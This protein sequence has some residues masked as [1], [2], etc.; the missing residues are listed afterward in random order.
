MGNAT[1]DGRCDSA[2]Q[3]R[4]HRTARERSHRRASGPGQSAGPGGRALVRRRSAAV[5][6]RPRSCAGQPGADTKGSR[7]PAQ[8]SFHR[9]R[10]R[11]EGQRA[12]GRVGGRHRPP[13]S[14]SG[15]FRR[16][17]RA[18]A[19]AAGGVRGHAVPCQLGSQV[20]PGLPRA[21]RAAAPRKV[22]HGG[23]GRRRAHEANLGG[24]GGRAGADV[25]RG[26]R[27]RAR[28]STRQ[29]AGLRGRA[30]GD[31]RPARC[32]RSDAPS[33]QERP[34]QGGGLHRSAGE[35]ERAHRGGRGRGAFRRARS[36][37]RPCAGAV[38][39]ARRQS[40]HLGRGLRADR[41]GC[42]HARRQRHLVR[43]GELPGNAAAAH[44]RRRAG[45]GVSAITARTPVPR[46]RRR[47]GVGRLARERHQCKRMAARRAVAR[48]DRTG[49]ALSRTHQGRG[50]RRIVPHRRLGRRDGARLTQTN[51][52]PL[53]MTAFVD[54]L[55]REL[56]PT[57][58]RGSA[59]FRLTLACVIAT[60]P[61]LTHRIPHALIVMIMMYL[62]TQEDTAATLLG[63]V[64]GVLGVTVGLGAALLVWMVVLDI[65]W[66]RIACFFGFTFGGLWLKRVLVV[67]AL[68][69]A[70]GLPAA[71]VMIL[72][73]VGPLPL[74]SLTEFVLWLWLTVTLGLTVNVGVQLLLAPGDPLTLLRR[75]RDTRLRLV[76]NALRELGG[77][78]DLDPAPSRVSL[79]TLATAGMSRPLALLKT[80]SLT[81]AWARQ[82]HDALAT[83]ITLV[84]RL[85]TDARALQL[86]LS[87]APNAALNGSLLRLA[88]ACA[89]TRQALAEQASP[90]AT[91]VAAPPIP[92]DLHVA[93]PRP[94]AEMERTLEQ[95]SAVAR[96][97]PAAQTAKEP[98]HRLLLPDATTNPEYVQF[99]VKGA[100]AALICYILFIG[101]DYPGIYTSVITCFVV[102]LSTIGSSNQKG[103]LR[104]GGAAVGGV[105]GLVALVYA[106]PNVEGVGGFWLVFATGTAGAAWI[107]FGSPRISYGGYQTGLAFYKATLQSV[108]TAVSATVVRDRLVGVAFGLMVFGLVEHFLWPAR[109]ADRMHERLADVFRSLAAFARVVS[110][111]ADEQGDVDARRQLIS[112]QVTD[113]QGFIESSKFEPGAG[114]ADAQRV[115]RLTADAQAVF[116][117]LLAISR[118]AASSARRPDAGRAATARV[119]QEVAV[120]LEALADRIGPGGVAS[121]GEVIGSRV[122]FDRS[123]TAAHADAAGER[124]TGE[125]ALGLYRELAVAVNRLTESGG[126]S[127]LT[128]ARSIVAG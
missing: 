83:A 11:C 114:A 96:L 86:V 73:D 101:F 70:L 84:D 58:G 99:A 76:E 27:R 15:G 1:A 80:A 81:N 79:E 100:L 45:R 43:D 50:S 117:I 2:R 52:E 62:I 53:T 47:P 7:G 14:R 71:L 24:H 68:G 75:E 41:S 38:H 35:L 128:G 122:D 97:A 111:P 23:Q 22:H 115:E 33:V 127:I 39:R 65:A 72:P 105:M 64:L 25:R 121:A 46:H 12:A 9:R 69:S 37:I 94:L 126:R 107:N 93:M 30:D 92:A 95:L 74:E 19:G 21:C 20:R 5:R 112:Q 102:S 77:S 34:G 116:L 4:G 13:R 60:I 28:R 61:V 40:E 42:L 56:A 17:D 123:F 63:S 104:F 103:L 85:V 54:F 89:H 110:R 8:R 90:Q 32:H 87:S 16:R 113:V 44:S 6:D 51:R 29:E 66:L 124:A 125:G 57:P 55:R 98:G 36:G 109:A 49:R 78:R 67:G 31:T 82:H 48:L 88:D 108:G 106:F 59:T 119:D 26:H 91:E 18:P 118:D 10:R 3:F 120:I